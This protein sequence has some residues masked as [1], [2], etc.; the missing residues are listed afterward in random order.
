MPTADRAARRTVHRHRRC[1]SIGVALILLGAVRRRSGAGTVLGLLAVGAILLFIAVALLS[2]RLVPP[3]ATAV[4]YPIERL[5]GVAGPACP[6]ERLRNPSRTA[7]TAAALMIGLA[8]VTFVSV[9]AAGVKASIDDTI[10][11]DLKAQFVVQNKDGFSPI[12]AETGE[13]AVKG[14]PACRRSPR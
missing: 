9:L 3:I 10:S 14:V 8:L 2:P 11:K 1:W 7:V 13:R 5:R 6:R 4:G 12:P